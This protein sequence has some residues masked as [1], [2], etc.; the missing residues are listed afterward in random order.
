MVRSEANHAN[1]DTFMRQIYDLIG[2][3]FFAP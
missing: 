1:Y 3:K 2:Y